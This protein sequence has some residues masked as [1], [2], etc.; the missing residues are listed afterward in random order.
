MFSH[1]ITL[2]GVL[3][4]TSVEGHL[5]ALG[6]SSTCNSSRGCLA[7]RTEIDGAIPARWLLPTEIQILI[8]GD[9]CWLG[10]LTPRGI[11][12]V[13]AGRLADT[14]VSFFAVLGDGRL[15]SE[16]ALIDP[17]LPWQRVHVVGLLGK[18]CQVDPNIEQ[19]QLQLWHLWLWEGRALS[20]LDW[21]PGEWR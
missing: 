12:L 14:S 20:E 17:L 3:L 8:P 15:R 18:A 2:S 4:S 19:D 6:D 21:D 16:G 9:A 13:V 7:R 5:Q 1:T 10:Q 11:P